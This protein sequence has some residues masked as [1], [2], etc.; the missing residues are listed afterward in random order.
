VASDTFHYS[1]D[2]QELILASLIQ[3]QDKL[4]FL[5]PALKSSYFSGVYATLAAKAALDY[6]S[7]RGRFPSFIVLS[8][9]LRAQVSQ[10]NPGD[11]DLAQSY[12][13]RL[14][15]MDTADYLYV[16]DNLLKFAKERAVV[17]AIHQS[18]E[19]L[20]K[21]ELPP[22]G[23]AKLFV[24]AMQVGE[25]LDD[26]G[27]ILHADTDAVVDK[28]TKV[29]YGISTGYA[30]LDRIWKHG[31]GP[32]WL[33]VPLAPPKRYKTAFA[34][35]LALNMVG[36]AI[37][38]DII[39]YACELN[40]EQAMVRAMVHLAKL[41]ED[42]MYESPV[43][44]KEAVKTA[45]QGKVAGNLLFKSFA[46]KGAKMS[47]LRAH[48][49]SAIAQL[50]IK[51]KAIFIDYAETVQPSDKREAEYRQQANI[52]VEARALA[53]EFGVTVIMPDR[54]NKDTV[55]KATPDMKS[56]QGAFEKAGVVDVALGL[57]AT[58]EEYR[59]YVIRVFNFLNRHGRAYQH[60]RGVVDPQTWRFELQ[61]EVPYEPEANDKPKKRGGGSGSDSHAGRRIP[62][63]L[64]EQA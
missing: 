64:L 50:K 58:D 9:M 1:S 12:V 3:H 46:S 52:Y 63:E 22:D 5:A 30:L 43:K 17:G 56:F 40:Q 32:G 49:R 29:G 51:P 33:V 19:I 36:P 48:A 25:N 54:C 6:N 41:P 55:D 47:D 62:A 16:R 11:A 38:E 34:I 28:V 23:F 42:Y 27:Y 44:F 2:F 60:L 20:K 15:E 53:S 24:E 14:S 39:Y 13:K 18:V 35:N 57:C 31:W 7:T 10:L 61:E 4:S 8:E 26:L 59:N 37:G 45:L 21:G